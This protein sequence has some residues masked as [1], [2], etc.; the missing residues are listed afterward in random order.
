MIGNARKLAH[1]R[2]SGVNERGGAVEAG[3]RGPS[4]ESGPMFRPRAVHSEALSASHKV[5]I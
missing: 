1:N 5:P 3:C 4:I 2:R